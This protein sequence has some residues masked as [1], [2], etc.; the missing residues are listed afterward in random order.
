MK[1]N[2]EIDKSCIVPFPRTS[3]LGITKNYKGII[4]TVIAAKVYNTLL[5]NRIQPE[6][7]KI[8][9]KIATY[10]GE[11]DTHPITD[12]DYSSNRRRSTCQKKKKKKKLVATLLFINFFKAFDFIHRKSIEQ[13]LQ[14]Y[15]FPVSLHPI[16]SVIWRSASDPMS[17]PLADGTVNLLICPRAFDSDSQSIAN[18]SR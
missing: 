14:A 13:I 4:L 17:V 16:S 10:F 9:W 7:E 1:Y 6:I 15:G 5:L 3:D 11:I 2:R 12:Y 18:K 8:F